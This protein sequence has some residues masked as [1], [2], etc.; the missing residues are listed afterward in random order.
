[1]AV[2]LKWPRAIFSPGRMVMNRRT[3]FSALGITEKSGQMAP[4]KMCILS[5]SITRG[6]P[7]TVSG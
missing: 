5:V 4:L 1:M 3:G 6:V 7:T 2:M